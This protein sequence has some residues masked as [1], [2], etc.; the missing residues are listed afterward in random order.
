M[1]LRAVKA[2]R[3]VA[4]LIAAELIVPPHNADNLAAATCASSSSTWPPDLMRT[5]AVVVD[6]GMR[7]DDGSSRAD[8]IRRHCSIG[9]EV[10]I[11]RTS[12]PL[13]PHSIAVFLR[14]PRFFGLFGARLAQI[15]YLD[16]KSEAMTKVGTTEQEA[17]AVVKS[18]YAPDEKDNPRVTIM[19]D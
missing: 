18:V 11:R 16:T 12:E 6:T 2:S 19:I 13:G 15:G 3:A 9:R 8:V 7:N 5:V 17:R 1:H 4:T 10:F 14:V